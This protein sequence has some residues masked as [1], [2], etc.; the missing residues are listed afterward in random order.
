MIFE[1][2]Q[3]ESALINLDLAG[4]ECSGGSACSSGSLDASHVLKA[5][6]VEESRAKC[7]LR[8]TLGRGSTKEEIDIAVAELERISGQIR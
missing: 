3:A 4:I 6:G 2:M 8:F 1:N 7:A 5:M